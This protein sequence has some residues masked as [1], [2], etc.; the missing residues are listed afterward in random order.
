MTIRASQ[1]RRNIAAALMVVGAAAAQA[2]ELMPSFAGVPGGWVT[3]RYAPAQFANVGTYM[4][5]SDTLAIGISTADAFDNRPA[6]YQS[7]FYNTQGMQYA[8]SGGAG[9]TISSG[10]FVDA[11][12]RDGS[13]GNV[14]TDM[15]GVASDGSAAVSGYPIIGFTNYD[16][17]ARYRVW[18][19]DG[20][21]IDLATAVDFGAWTDFSIAFTGTSFDY[22]I[23]NVMVYS[24]DGIEGSVG[25]SAVIMQAYNFGGDPSLAGAVGGDYTV[26]WA[27]A[28]VDGD[29]PEPASLALVGLALAGAAVARRR[30]QT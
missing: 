14:R 22:F 9:S 12:W 18:D 1:W 23:N 6:A 16:G 21:W 30:R 7:T 2:G 26:R 29:V 17:A 25:F 19:A 27:A 15:W 28:A 11:A 20:M 10:L 8:V 3:D 5:R 24:D 4:G 13:A